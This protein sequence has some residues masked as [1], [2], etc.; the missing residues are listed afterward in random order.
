MV[1]PEFVCCFVCL[2]C[3][4]ALSSACLS[5]VGKDSRSEL[6]RLHCSELHWRD[7]VALSVGQPRAPVS[8]KAC[9]HGSDFFRS[10]W[11]PAGQVGAMFPLKYC[12]CQG[13]CTVVP[14]CRYTLTLCDFGATQSANTA[15]A[16]K[17][18]TKRFA[19]YPSSEQSHQTQNN[20]KSQTN[21]QNTPKHAV[22][23]RQLQLMQR[24]YNITLQRTSTQLTQVARPGPRLNTSITDLVPPESERS[25][26]CTNVA[27]PA[28]MVNRPHRIQL[29]ATHAFVDR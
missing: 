4:V 10:R 9:A 13:L 27:E 23:G 25:H 16:S 2:G 15:P 3:P 24:A 29:T 1:C 6:S 12:A 21:K 8:S 11:C 5:C 14:T 20:Q 26:P 18:G 19:L 22:I 17:I 28:T 7:P